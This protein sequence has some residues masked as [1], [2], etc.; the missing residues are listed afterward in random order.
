[1]ALGNVYKLRSWIQREADPLAVTR[2]ALSA[3]PYA[4]KEA[5][6]LNKLHPADEVSDEVFALLKAEAE[7]IVGKTYAAV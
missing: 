2:W 4:A 3:N 6:R 7:R 5:V 1:M